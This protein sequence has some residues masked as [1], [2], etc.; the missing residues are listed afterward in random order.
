MNPF[1]Q[2]QLTYELCPIILVG[3]IAKNVPGS[4]L[5]VISLTQAQDF[6]NGLLSSSDALKYENFLAHFMPMAGGTLIENQI[7]QYPFA[8][9]YI[10]ANAIIVQPLKVSLLMIAP[11]PTPGGYPLKLAAF[12]SI[13]QQLS[14]HNIMGGTYTVS[15]PS[16]IY[17]NMLLLSLRDASGGEGSQVQVKWQWEFIQPLLTQAAATQAYSNLMS[18]MS[19]RLPVAGD[20]PTQSGTANAVG[21]QGSGVTPA[22]APAA[23]QAGGANAGVRGQPVPFIDSITT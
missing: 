11:A 14:K 21:S 19:G 18:K 10:A 16:M 4:L 7:G 8:N 6:E 2:F 15:T 13:Q 23:Q 9:Q 20:P 22:I 3:G 5:P 12:T 17:T 1:Q